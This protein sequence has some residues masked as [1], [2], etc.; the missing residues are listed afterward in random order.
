MCDLSC[1]LV[2]ILFDV[3]MAD[4]FIFA[5]IQSVQSSIMVFLVRSSFN[6]KQVCEMHDMITNLLH[7]SGQSGRLVSSRNVEVVRSETV[8]GEVDLWSRCGGGKRQ[9][10][11]STVQERHIT[12]QP[13]PKVACL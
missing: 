1:N 12:S 9:Q 6:T 4:L 2:I 5:N 11:V 3:R 8:V 13:V 7:E 10:W